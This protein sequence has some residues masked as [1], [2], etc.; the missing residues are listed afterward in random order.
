M[1]VR[2]SADDLIEAAKN[3]FTKAGADAAIAD[4]MARIL[5]EADMLG[6]STHGLQFVPAYL[7]QLESGKTASSG[8]PEIIVDNGS[9]LVLDGKKLPGQWVMIQ[10]LEIAFERIKKSPMTGIAIRNTANISCLATYA[11]RAALEGY[12]AIV[13][14]SAPTNSAVAPFGGASPVLSTNPFAIGIPGP[15]HPL[16]IDTSAAAVT[17]RAIERAERLGERLPFKGLVAADGK[18]SDDPADFRSDP[19]G[20]IRPAGGDEAGHKGFALGLLVEALTSGLAGLGRSS[21]PKPAGNTVFLQ[22]IDPAGFAGRDH[23]V[24]EVGEL[25]SLCRGATPR[26]PDRPVRVPGDRAAALFLDQSAR[27]VALHPEI[28]GLFTPC[29]EKYGIPVPNPLD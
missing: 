19:P 13:A 20:A 10:A 16:L 3:L 27:G 24:R 17:N 22:L 6:Y 14:A 4:A 11:R 28:M 8:E 7:A 21:D 26:V 23:L 25:A 12:F 18:A 5:V 29:L 9:T 2:Y 15:D 1:T